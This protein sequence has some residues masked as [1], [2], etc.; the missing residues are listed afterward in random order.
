MKGKLRSQAREYSMS[1]SPTTPAKDS[2]TKLDHINKSIGSKE[3]L[4]NKSLRNL[5]N[6]SDKIEEL[7]KE[8]RSMDR[9]EM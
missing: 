8:S 7:T 9:D 5:S 2:P 3:R 6:N 1:V 4:I